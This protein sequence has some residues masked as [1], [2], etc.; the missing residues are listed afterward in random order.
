[1]PFFLIAI[2]HINVYI[3]PD[4]LNTSVGRQLPDGQSNVGFVF[5]IAGYPHL[6]VALDVR[7]KRQVFVHKLLIDI[8]NGA[9][10]CFLFH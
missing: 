1:M 3:A 6:I 4:A 9:Y 8:E 10:T 5:A 2:E 7:S